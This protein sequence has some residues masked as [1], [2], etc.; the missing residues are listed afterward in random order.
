ML[1][2]ATVNGLQLV[3]TYTDVTDLN[4]VNFVAASAFAV[5]SA[6]NEAISVSGVVVLGKTVTLTL[7]RYVHGGETVKLSYTKPATGDEGI[8][9][10][11]GNDAASLT[12]QAVSN[13]VRDTMAP[14]LRNNATVRGDLL[15]LTYADA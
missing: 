13:L 8:R 12:D 11:A 2:S 9:D 14:V 6:G 1:G 3:L 15:E 10:R 4:E 5:S 7:S